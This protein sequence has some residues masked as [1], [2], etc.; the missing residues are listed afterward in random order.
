MLGGR[1]RLALLLAAGLAAAA[2]AYSVLRGSRA[3]SSAA[4][5]ELSS[6]VFENGGVIPARYT[7]DGEDVSPPL[8]W[9]G[10]LEGTASLALIVFDPDAPGGKFTHWLIYGIPARV[11]AL[12]EGVPS[13]GIV[14]GLGV[15]G[16]NDF[17][18]VGRGGPC[19]PR[20]PAHRYV[21]R[22]LA[23]DAD[24]DLPPGLTRGELEE[25]VEG[26][27]LGVGELVGLYSRP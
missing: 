21:F 3:P 23:L 11:K 2:L 24:L 19:P 25:A 18:R 16:R 1:W 26:H 10:L 6:P 15:Q 5:I 7:C 12:P 27:V 8:E 20:G 14:A 22:L 17:G 4:R 9:K 13:E